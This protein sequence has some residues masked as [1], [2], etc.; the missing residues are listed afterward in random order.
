MAHYK[1]ESPLFGSVD[2]IS[3]EAGATVEEGDTL[4][5]IS[6]MKML[7]YVESPADGVFYPL[8]PIGAV[9]SADQWIGKVQIETPGDSK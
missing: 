7:Y 6:A 5:I 1:I 4:F 2:Q 9:V 8:V 3:F